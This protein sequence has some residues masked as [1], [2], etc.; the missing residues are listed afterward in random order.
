MQPASRKTH[1]I[2]HSKTN[3]QENRCLEF[4]NEFKVREREKK[5]TA[6][7]PDRERELFASQTNGAPNKISFWPQFLASHKSSLS[8]QFPSDA[9]FIL[10]FF[11]CCNFK[12][13]RQKEK[14]QKALLFNRI[15]SA[16]FPC[17]PTR[18]LRRTPANLIFFIPLESP[19]QKL[20]LRISRL[21]C[22]LV[23]GNVFSLEAF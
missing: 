21:R 4:E 5:C 12:I 8:P 2:L 6:R 17:L 19:M 13:S 16:D 11:F 15:R 7:P 18:R 22:P 14:Q 1:N 10:F 3:L 20:V 23:G 9:V